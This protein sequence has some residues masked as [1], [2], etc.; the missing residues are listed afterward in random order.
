MLS[1]REFT[2][3]MLQATR[4]D[5]RQLS[6]DTNPILFLYYAES[7]DMDIDAY[8]NDLPIGRFTERSATL[9]DVKVGV[10]L[11]ML[12]ESFGMVH[13]R[14]GCSGQETGWLEIKLDNTTSERHTS[15]VHGE[16]IIDVSLCTCGE[17]HLCDISPAEDTDTAE[18][19][20]KRAGLLAMAQDET[21]LSRM[22]HGYTPVESDRLKGNH[23]S[24]LAG[25]VAR[26]IEAV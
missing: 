2:T 21:V 4:H 1:T 25:L 11:S 20:M 5:G 18:A 15:D 10:R 3:D 14:D 6:R 19:A 8:P 9:E 23:L 26:C 16:V 24:E 17:V 12:N 13:L 7:M 22:K